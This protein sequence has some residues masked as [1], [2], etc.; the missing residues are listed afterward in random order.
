MR[1]IL[2]LSICMLTLVACN[3]AK[4][5][6]QEEVAKIVQ[7]P[8]GENEEEHGCLESAGYTWSKLKQNCIQLFNEGQRLNP[9]ETKQDEALLSAFILFNEDRTGIE[10]FIPNRKGSQVV[11]RLDTE[12][13]YQNETYRF[14]VKEATLYINGS[15]KYK[16]EQ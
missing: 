9:I 14:D 5:G 12:D 11:G 6:S 8:L 13:V 2:Y 7:I 15:K 1:K 3:K 16:A 10:L 4:S